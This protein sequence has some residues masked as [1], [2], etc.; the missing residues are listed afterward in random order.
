[1]NRTEFRTQISYDQVKATY[2][3]LNPSQGSGIIQAD[4][5]AYQS[6]KQQASA[7]VYLLAALMVLTIAL[8]FFASKYRSDVMSLSGIQTEIR[9]RFPLDVRAWAS[10]IA[11]AALFGILMECELYY[12]SPTYISLYQISIVLIASA[13]LVIVCS[14][15]RGAVALLRHP[16]DLAQEWSPA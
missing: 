1:M 14:G 3:I 4:Y 2:Y 5:L 10:F 13:L 15:L 11:A 7:T 6:M 8:T 16:E 9:K 12:W